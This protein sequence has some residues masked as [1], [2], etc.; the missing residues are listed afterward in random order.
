MQRFILSILALCA[1]VLT[2]SM[3]T[4]ATEA[5]AELK[6][7]AP[8][9]IK[10]TKNPVTFP[11]AKHDA[12]GVECATC[13]HTWDSKSDVQSCSTAGCHDQPG[14]KGE[15]AYYSAFHAKNADNSCLG[16]HK[17]MKKEG[18]VVPVSCKDCHP[19]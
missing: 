18:K 17:I 15:T 1:L 11:H 7:E 4:A 19:K 5:P 16:C 3:A 9:G 13:H 10:A 14:K 6:L 12:A 2:V 8:A